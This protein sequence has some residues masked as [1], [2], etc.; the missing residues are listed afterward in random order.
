MD[1]HDSHSVL[2]G[3]IQ[4][5]AFAA[6]V[7]IFTLGVELSTFHF[8]RLLFYLPCPDSQLLFRLEWIL[9]SLLRI[10]SVLPLII[11]AKNM[12]WMSHKWNKTRV[13]S[14]TI[15]HHP[16]LLSNDVFFKNTLL[17]LSNT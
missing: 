11:W 12:Q 15:S 10:V 16:T 5:N 6:S 17:M 13:L 8:E 2:Y 1:I 4:P 9:N 3:T 14:S 7:L